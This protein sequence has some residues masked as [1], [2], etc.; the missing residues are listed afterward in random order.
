[1]RGFLVLFPAQ[2]RV[3]A[4]SQPRGEWLVRGELQLLEREGAVEGRR[5]GTGGRSRVVLAQA[6]RQ[7]GVPPGMSAQTLGFERSA[8]LPVALAR[9]QLGIEHLGSR[10]ERER[11]ASVGLPAQRGTGA[12]QAVVE[13]KDAVLVVVAEELAADGGGDR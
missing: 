7:L 2:S 1:M 10:P 12:P 11:P 8:H 5:V 9:I 4:E 3:E 6:G 13:K